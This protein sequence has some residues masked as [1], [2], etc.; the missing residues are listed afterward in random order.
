MVEDRWVHAARHFTS[1][2]SSFQPCDIYR[3]CPR[4]V[5]RRPK[6]A[7]NVLKWRTFELTGWITGKRLKIDG[8]IL[9]CVWQTL[10]PLSIHVTFTTIFQGVSRGS[11]KCLRLSWRS[12]MPPPA[13]RVKATTY[14]RDCPEVAKL[15]LRLVFMQLTRDLFAIAKFLYFIQRTKWWRWILYAYD[16]FSPFSVADET[17]WN[18]LPPDIRTAPTPSTFKNL[19]KTHL[20]PCPAIL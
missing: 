14:R 19:L 15:W 16:S 6:C 7:K 12:Q 8:Y 18:S 11:Q 20:F 3:N 2:Q 13:K 10:N 9:Q 1:I 4:G 5:A 17:A